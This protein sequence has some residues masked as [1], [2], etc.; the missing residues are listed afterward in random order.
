MRKLLIITFCLTS[1]ITLASPI[2][3]HVA[4]FAHSYVGTKNMQVYTQASHDI[5]IINNTDEAKKFTFYYS[6]CADYKNCVNIGSSI[7]VK[8]HS[9]WNNHHDSYLSPSY[10]WEGTFNLTAKTVVDGDSHYENDAFGYI[11]VR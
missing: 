3:V 4:S 8:P 1:S 5:E 7:T 11:N 2:D 6:Y 10:S 9:K